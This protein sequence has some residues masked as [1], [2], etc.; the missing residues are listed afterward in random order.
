MRLTDEY[1]LY[2]FLSRLMSEKDVDF[3]A[4]AVSHWHAIGVDAF[5]YDL[6][7]R[8]NKKLRGVIIILPHRKDRF[9]IS[10]VDFICNNF[11]EVE[12]CFLDVNPKVQQ[13][14]VFRG[15]K[16]I[17]R[18]FDI[19][20]ATKSIRNKNKNKKEIYIVS[21]MN[22]N[23]NFLQ[24]FRNKHL[25]SKYSPAFSLIDEGV[26][27][28]MSKKMWKIVRELNYQNKELKHFQFV[29]VIE[30]KIFEIGYSFLKNIALKYISTENRFLF[31]KKQDTLI[32]IWSVVNSYKK[33]LEKRKVHIKKVK[34]T[35]PLAIIVTQPFL[36]YEQLSV[37]YEL[38]I[39]ESVVNILVQRGI[40]VAIKPHPRETV[41]K[42]TSILTKFKSEQI[43]L[44]QQKTPVEDF[45]LMLNPACVIG[46]TSTSLVNARVLYNI[47]TISIINILLETT[48][49]E[50]LNVQKNEFKKLAS[51]MNIFFI[52]SIE[53]IGD[54][55][56]DIKT[57]NKM[58]EMSEKDEK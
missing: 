35:G 5:I 57:K 49:A 52:N 1:A 29:Q 23:I 11:A 10:E 42:Y 3:I 56:D 20:L 55:L 47:P 31:S 24:I 27:T 8:K 19:L 44:I 25:A 2:Q 26:G 34:N 28:Y 21:V 14:T 13:S 22:P 51:N 30:L 18:I 48:N 17:K 7:E 50:M 32:P 39:T 16:R 45:F 41:D 4:W 6:S 54:V 37:E 15:V 40:S 33:V 12:F 58:G 53:E 38:N 43:E 46:Y 36:E 9:V